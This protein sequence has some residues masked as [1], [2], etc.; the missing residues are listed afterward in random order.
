MHRKWLQLHSRLAS[1]SHRLATY[2]P[3]LVI[4]DLAARHL[5]WLRLQSTTRRAM[6]LIVDRNIE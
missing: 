5:G 4:A 6:D 1:L 2:G 3:Q